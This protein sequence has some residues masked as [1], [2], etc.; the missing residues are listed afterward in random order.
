MDKVNKQSVET[1]LNLYAFGKQGRFGDCSDPKP[2]M[3]AFKD[4]KKWESWEA[5]KGLDQD[6]AKKQFILIAKP[7]LGK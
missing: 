1:R 2:G 6:E 4:K 5:I 7:V 3:F